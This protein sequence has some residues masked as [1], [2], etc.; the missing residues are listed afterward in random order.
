M[1]WNWEH[2]SYQLIITVVYTLLG[3]L[4]LGF[5]YWLIN[6]YTVFSLHDEII[7]KNNMALAILLGAVVIGVA[8]IVAA[9]IRG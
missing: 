6:K 4:C 5:A 3:L 7:T 9:A 2:L 8:L 1:D